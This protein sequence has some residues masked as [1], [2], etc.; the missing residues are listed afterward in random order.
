MACL[1]W[2]FDNTLAHRPGLWS[3]CLAD[4]ANAALPGA[5]L[6]RDALVP[7]LTSGFPWHRPGQGHPELGDADTWWRALLPVLASALVHSGQVRPEEA[8]GIAARARADYTD[9]ARWVVFPDT[10]PSLTALTALGWRH[11]ILSNHV[12]E[13]PQLVAALGLGHH[14]ERILTSA[15]LGWE[16]PHPAAFKAARDSCDTFGNCPA[17]KRVVMIGDSF[18]A[19]YEGARAAGIEAILVRTTHPACERALPDLEAVVAHLGAPGS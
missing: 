17:S 6:T 7:H 10:V 14:F 1:I 13:L 12:P 2:D 4:V 11:L 19:D 3:Q 16:K 5:G 9:P 8:R 18:V 15:A